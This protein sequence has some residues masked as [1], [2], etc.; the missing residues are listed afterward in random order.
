[1]K[2]LILLFGVAMA[3]DL[4]SLEDFRKGAEESIKKNWL[5]VVGLEWLQEGKPYAWPEQNPV[6]IFEMKKKRVTVKI[7]DN[8]DIKIDGKAIQKDK[9]YSLLSDKSD[10]KT[11]IEKHSYE[12]FIIDRPKGL[13]VR[14]KNLQS[15]ALKDFAGIPW[16]ELKQDYIVK[17]VWK[18]IKPSRTIKIPDIQGEITEEK[19]SGFVEF[20]LKGQ[21]HELYPTQ[22]GSKLFFVFKDL[23]SGKTSY[24]PGRFLNAELA[25]DGTVVMDFNRATNPPC[26][27]ISFATCPLPPIENYLKIE[28]EAGAQKPVK[29]H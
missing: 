7:L 16:W 4:K 20:E 12:L 11:T 25:K 2:L 10:F 28:I 1:M 17:G 26:A 14:I 8:K 21:K 29:G 3:T 19:I 5:V 24:G 9:T 6:M 13:G 15:D 18:K 23:T 22:E 27:Y